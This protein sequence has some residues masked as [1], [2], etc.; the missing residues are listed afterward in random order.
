MISASGESTVSVRSDINIA[1]F[2]VQ[3]DGAPGIFL[4][5]FVGD[6][7]SISGLNC[8]KVGAGETVRPFW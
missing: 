6:S 8:S 4:G 7:R 5:C 1:V 3:R 2:L